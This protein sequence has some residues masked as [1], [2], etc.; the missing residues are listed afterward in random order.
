MVILNKLVVVV[1]VVVV[2]DCPLDTRFFRS[3]FGG[4]QRLFSVKYPVP[5]G[6]KCL[7]F[8]TII[9]YLKVVTVHQ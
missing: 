9:N 1:V 5:R 3:L 4:T 8:S 7:G 2:V 6:I